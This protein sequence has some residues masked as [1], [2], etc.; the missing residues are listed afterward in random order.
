MIPAGIRYPVRYRIALKAANRMAARHGLTLEPYAPFVA[1]AMAEQGWVGTFL[2]ARDV[3][4]A[5]RPAER[6]GG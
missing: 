4:R 6:T 5:T 1:R 3:R 2:Y